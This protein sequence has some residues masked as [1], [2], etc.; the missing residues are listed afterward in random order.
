M[1]YHLATTF[2]DDIIDTAPKE[3]TTVQYWQN[4]AANNNFI[5]R[6]GALY[7]NAA[8]PLYA[9][10][11]EQ[12]AGNVAWNLLRGVFN[13]D[14]GTSLYIDGSGNM[15]SNALSH[16]ADAV[17]RWPDTDLFPL[18]GISSFQA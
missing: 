10:I 3:P 11:W 8:Q 15:L 9:G 14:F 12:N 2:Q 7:G 1:R 5:L 4:W 16:V 13:H 6:W 18:V 17:A